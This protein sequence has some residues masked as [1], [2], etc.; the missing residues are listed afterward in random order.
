MP[1]ELNNIEWNAFK[2]I[3]TQSPLII[4][5]LFFNT[6][7]MFEYSKYNLVTYKNEL[8]KVNLVVL[9]ASCFL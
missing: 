6:S 5:T 9:S 8:K 3:E 2:G 7:A 4:I 1:I